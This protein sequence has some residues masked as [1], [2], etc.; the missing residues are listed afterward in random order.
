[1]NK[2][3]KCNAYIV[4]AK[5]KVIKTIEGIQSAIWLNFL[6]TPNGGNTLYVFGENKKLMYR[7]VRDNYGIPQKCYED[8]GKTF[9]DIFKGD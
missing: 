2:V 9:E 3:E 4:N 5:D 8:K 1:M 6:T 7:S